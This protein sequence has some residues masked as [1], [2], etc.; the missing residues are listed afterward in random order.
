MHDNQKKLQQRVLQSAEETLYKQHYVSAIDLFIG[1]NLLQP[2]HV[3]DWKKGKIPYLEKVIQGS[4]G[5]ITFSMKCFRGWASEKGLKPRCTEYFVKTSGPKRKLK[6]SISGAPSL[7]EFYRTHYICPTLSEKKQKKLQE[8]LDKP[9]ELVVFRTVSESQCSQCKKK[10]FKG[11]F[12]FMEGDVPLCH[13][14]C[15]GGA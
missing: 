9:S 14:C 11:S 15:Q 3:N 8:K 2:Q 10:L 12:V 13:S 6:F 1:M 7:E 5:K 4:L